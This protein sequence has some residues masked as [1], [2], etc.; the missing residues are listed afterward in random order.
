M[1]R[2]FILADA[3]FTVAAPHATIPASLGS[4]T[5]FKREIGRGK[6]DIIVICRLTLR[7]SLKFSACERC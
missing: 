7:T 6:K 5:Q 2:G 4:G 3:L 1:K